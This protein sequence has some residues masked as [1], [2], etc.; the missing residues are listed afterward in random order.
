MSIQSLNYLLIIN[1]CTSRMYINVVYKSLLFIEV[2]NKTAYC[3]NL[4]FFMAMLV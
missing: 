2:L 4:V 3:V 1:Q